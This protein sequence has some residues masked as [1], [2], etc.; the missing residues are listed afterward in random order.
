M[1]SRF[2]QLTR[3][4]SSL[5]EEKIMSARRMM[6]RVRKAPSLVCLDTK[7]LSASEAQGDLKLV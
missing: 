2:L 7:P 5:S 4:K 1:Q 6:G 3:P